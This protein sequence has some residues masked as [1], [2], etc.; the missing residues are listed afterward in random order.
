M[1][2]P[3]RRMAGLHRPLMLWTGAMA[4]LALVSFVGIVADPRIL[5]GVP[6]WLKV[7]KF[8]T[9]FVLYAS[10]MAWMLSLLPK[11]SRTAEWAATLVVALSLIEMVII[12]GQVIRG[13]T[14]HFNGT[15]PFNELLFNIMGASI[16][17]LWLAQ[18]VIAVVLVRAR[19]ADRAVAYGVRLGLLVSLL[20]MLAAVPMTMSSAVPG[21]EGITGAHSVGVLDGGPGMPITGWSLTG[22]DLR[23]GHFVG[24]HA[25]QALPL[26]AWVLALIAARSRR[27]GAR[28]GEHTRVRLLVVT[29]VAYTVLMTMLTWQALRGQPV[30]RPDALTLGAWALLVAGTV[31]AVSAVLAAG[32]RAAAAPTPAPTPAPTATEAPTARELVR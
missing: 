32:R 19:I 22:G 23:I 1:T 25:L 9:S 3:L 30:L 15:T 26:L 28:L 27:F 16:M 29:A 12:V 31:A 13:Q 6:I 17:V 21:V 24:L 20:G 18:L 2:T 10:T 11:R 4:V 5:T 7:F 14:S 8:S